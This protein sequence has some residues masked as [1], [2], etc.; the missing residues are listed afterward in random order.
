MQKQKKTVTSK[1]LFFWTVSEKCREKSHNQEI[2][3]TVLSSFSPVHFHFKQ[4][5]DLKIKMLS[6]NNRDGYEPCEERG[7]SYQMDFD[8]NPDSVF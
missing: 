4:Q 7:L 1:L 6:S 5:Q 8:L 2:E 3:T